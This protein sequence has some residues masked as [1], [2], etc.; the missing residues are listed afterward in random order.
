MHDLILIIV[1]GSICYIDTFLDYIGVF[2][3]ATI[4]IYFKFL[5]IKTT[6]N[7]VLKMQFALFLLHVRS[8]C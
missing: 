1:N 3:Y 4:N 7:F 8:V 2:Q 6:S 5:M